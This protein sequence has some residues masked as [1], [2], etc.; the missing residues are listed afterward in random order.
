MDTPV[1]RY[2][3]G[4]Y[5]RLGFAIAAHMQ[6]DIL[7]V[8]EVLAVG[9]AD[10]QR[11]CLG[12]MDEVERSGRTVLFVSHNLDAMAR[13][14]PTTVWL[15]AGQIRAIGPTE[16][17]VEAYVRSSVE[18]T[19]TKVVFDPDPARAAQVVATWIED[20]DGAEQSILTTRGSAWLTAEVLVRE[21]VPGLDLSFQV[22]TRGGI[23]IFDEVLSDVADPSMS[24]PG[25]HRIR[26]RLPPVLTPGEYVASVWLGTAYEQVQQL[27]EVVAFAVEGDDGGRARRL[28]KLSTEWRTERLDD[29][30]DG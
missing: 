14:C 17:I 19:S 3:S 21:S 16:H 5:L 4:M 20:D 22:A 28:V 9:D 15:E 18:R 25:L 1:K 26:W 12:K 27:D 11:R 2:S 6:S 10:F 24:D 7:L 29:H 23:G 30:V 13:L 8:D